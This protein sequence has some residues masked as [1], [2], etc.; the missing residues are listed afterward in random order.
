MAGEAPG[1]LGRLHN[2]LSRTRATLAARVDALLAGPIDEA[3]FTELEETLVQADV[4]VPL[5]GAITQQLRERSRGLSS[6]D[7]VRSTLAEIIGEMLGTPGVLHLD[8]PPAVILI[9]GANG[10][11]KTTTIAKLAH[12]L[13]QE[14]RRV[15]LAAGDTF[16]AA[17]IEQLEIWGGRVGAPVI[18]HQAGADPAAVVFDAAQAAVAR[19]ADVLIVDTAGRL[20]TKVNLM[21][22]LKKVNRVV[23]RALPAAPVERLLVLDATTGQNGLAQAKHFHDA[24]GLTGLVLTKLDGTAKGGIVVAVAQTLRVPI[25]FIGTGEG[26]DDLQP[27]HAAAFAEALLAAS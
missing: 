22:E 4:G 10:S 17:A 9:L 21:E 8:P 15:L 1:W 20:H 11:G 12:R 7:A 14:D 25:T 24:V 19:G 16:R 26:L 6:P 3:F 5:S 13:R 23:T 27:F 2:A 18:R